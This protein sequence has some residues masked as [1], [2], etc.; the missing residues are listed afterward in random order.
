[1]TLVVNLFGGPGTGKST[2]AALTFGKLKSQGVSAELVTEY[3]K[4][5][6]W[7]ERYHAL[8]FQ[9][10]IIAK[11]MWRIHKL[12]GKVDVIITD[13]PILLGLVYGAEGYGE[14]WKSHILEFFN[15]LDNLNVM[16][17]RN[18]EAHPYV[19]N[20]RTQTDV[21]EAQLIDTQIESLLENHSIPTEFIDIQENDQTADQIVH[22]VEMMI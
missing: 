13:S 9:P 3:A 20:G 17:I 1:M 19:A 21:G 14:G 15:S 6:V 10:Y 11:Q 12:L 7:E 8:G 2:N 4:D 22:L 5:L 18:D 16:L